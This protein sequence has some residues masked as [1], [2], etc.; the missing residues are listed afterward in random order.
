MVRFED[1]E[2][3]DYVPW[4]KN[5][6]VSSK[7]RVFSVKRKKFLKPGKDNYGY[8]KISL[9]KDGKGQTATV[10]RLVASTF[11]FSEDYKGCAI[12]HIDQN[13][14]NN[15]LLNLRFCS[16]SENKRNTGIT[17]TNTS[18]YK[19]VHWNIKAKKWKVGIRTNE[20]RKHLGY[21]T[22]KEEAYEAYKE[23]SKKYHGEYGYAP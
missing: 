15:N 3:W 7:G 16:T 11:Y 22:D 23:A 5:Y 6:K 20:G 19:G 2:I 12:D 21:F 9:C 18:G 8:H 13:K 4:N 10:H 1:L 14:T 17:V